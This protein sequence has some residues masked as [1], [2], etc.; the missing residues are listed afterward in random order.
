MKSNKNVHW[1]LEVNSF[2]KHKRWAVDQDYTDKLSEEEKQWLSQFNEEFYKNKV[3]KNDPKAL[4]N[5]DKLRKDCYSREN[6]ANRDLYAVK[7]TGNMIVGDSTITDEEGNEE[8]V[9]NTIADI[10]Q[11]NE[12]QIIDFIDKKYKK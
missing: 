9:L 3:K 1:G 6:A 5:T 8:S 10:N 12:C 4:H 11:L 7:A 2:P